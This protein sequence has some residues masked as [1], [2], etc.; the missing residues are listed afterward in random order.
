MTYLCAVVLVWI[1]SVALTLEHLKEIS[2]Y[3]HEQSQSRAVG[4]ANEGLAEEVK[5]GGPA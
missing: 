4:N 5:A 3:L 1:A 2:E